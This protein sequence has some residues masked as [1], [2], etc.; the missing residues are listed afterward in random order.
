MAA[1]IERERKV[2][3]AVERRGW[4]FLFVSRVLRD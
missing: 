2:M 1:G 4:P 3:K